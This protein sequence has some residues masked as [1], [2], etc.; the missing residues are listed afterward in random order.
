MRTGGS[1]FK[2]ASAAP[3]EGAKIVDWLNL[4]SGVNALSLWDSL[5]DAIIVSI[6]SD[7]L[8]RSMAMTFEVEHLRTFHNFGEGFRFILQ[9]D[10]VQ[11]ARV[12]RYV[13]WPGGCSIPDRLSRE[14]EHQLVAEY[15]SKWREESATWSDFESQIT[16]ENEQVFDISDAALAISP[17]GP[18]AVRLCGHLN[19]AT[20]HEVFVRSETPRILG[21]D[22]KEFGIEEFRGLGEAYWEAFS[23]RAE[24]RKS[25]DFQK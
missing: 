19:Y 25:V 2:D 9:L 14:E 4:P 12:L 17:S 22:G 7:L 18:A 5:H 23:R 16:R 3:D 20:Y 24:S 15:Q 6:R 13:I 10:G 1:E 11:S 8:S 21:S